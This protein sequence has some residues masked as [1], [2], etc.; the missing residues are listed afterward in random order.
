MPPI[1][2]RTA[3]Q[4][5]KQPVTGPA[6]LSNLISAVVYHYP[7]GGFNQTDVP[8]QLRA[9]QADYLKNRGYSLGYCF[10]I[11]GAIYEV[12]G[13]DIRNAANNGVPSKS[14]VQNYN[15]FTI[16]VQF[17]TDG[18]DPAPEG[19]LDRAAELHV[20]LER[21]Y[22]RELRIEGHGDKDA[23]PC[24]GAGIRSQLPR[25]AAK[26]QALRNPPKPPPLPSDGLPL[27]DVEMVILIS[28]N[29]GVDD[30]VWISNG[31]QKSWIPDQP[32][33]EAIQFT[34]RKDLGVSGDVHL[35]NPE[36]FRGYGISTVEYP[37]RDPWGVR[38]V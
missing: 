19:D 35:L 30:A 16:S 21:L 36:Q 29:D 14:G 9:M 18:A 1:I 37:G 27:K 20:W 38:V 23:T 31:P 8:A 5:P 6:T 13:V 24:P 15:P 25:L 33:L 34:L 32:A 4:S 2:D 11:C 3:W 28:C 17:G 22:G 10:V 26:V 12:R 7:G